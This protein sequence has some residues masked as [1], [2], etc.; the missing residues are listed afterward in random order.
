[1]SFAKIPKSDQ[2]I[3]INYAPPQTSWME[4]PVDF[5]PGTWSYSGVAK[6]LTY[7][8]LPNPRSWQ[9]GDVDWKLPE[10]WQAIILCMC[11]LRRLRG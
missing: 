7:L 6:N 11:P 1:M 3:T 4:T 5:R 9:P 8:D 2:L 10:N